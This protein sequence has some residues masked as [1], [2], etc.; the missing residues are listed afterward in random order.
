M[1]NKN[2]DNLFKELDTLNTKVEAAP[3]GLIGQFIWNSN[4]STHEYSTRS[5]TDHAEVNVP[6]EQGRKYKVSVRWSVYFSG[7]LGR[8]ITLT[9]SLNGVSRIRKFYG[10]ESTAQVLSVAEVFDHTGADVAS[11]ECKTVW[12]GTDIEQG[13]V[14]LLCEDVGPI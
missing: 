12:V 6:L 9:T 1:S 10:A 7:G 5:T 8:Y 4:D 14:H 11:S 2:L 3:R 13:F